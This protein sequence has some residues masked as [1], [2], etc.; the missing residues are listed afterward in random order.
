MMASLGAATWV[1]L[2]VWT[3]IGALVYVLYGYRHSCLRAGTA[4]A[5]A[6]ARPA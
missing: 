5:A 4:A 6:S 3:V 1:R 2:I